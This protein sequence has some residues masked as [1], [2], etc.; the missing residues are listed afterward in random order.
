[1]LSRSHAHGRAW[2]FKGR[3]IAVILV[4]VLGANWG[5]QTWQRR[6]QALSEAERLVQSLTRVA[7]YQFAGSLRSVEALLDEAADRVDPIQWPQPELEAWFHARLAGYPELRAMQVIGLD[8]RRVGNVIVSDSEAAPHLAQG[9]PGGRDFFLQLQKDYAKQITAIGAPVPTGDGRFCIPV[10][11]AIIDRDGKFAGVVTAG[12][13]AGALREKL[14]SVAVEDDGGSGLFRRDALILARVPGHDQWLGK[15]V[16][17]SAVFKHYLSKSDTGIG[18]LIGVADGN[19][20]IIAYRSFANYPLV[21]V[22]GITI[23]SALAEWYQQVIKEGV[24]NI[25]V[26][27]ALLA[28]AT[29]Y[30]RRSAAN[31]QLL[32]E[33][34]ANRDDLER[35]VVERTAH[36][37]ATNAEL[38]QFT[39]IASHDLQEPLRS[40]SSFLQL[41]ERRYRGQLDAEA[42]EYIAF[43]VNGAKRMSALLNDVLA[44]SQ[45][46][47]VGLAPVCCD[48]ESL[49]REA[50]DSLAEQVKAVDPDIV[51]EPLPPVLAV[52]SQLLTLFQNLLGNALKYRALERRLRV[53]VSA[54]K[55]APG[56]VRISV[57]DNGIGI[58][59]QYHERIFKIFQRL[60]RRE[61]FEGTG[62][63]L[64]LC[65]KIVETVGG[66]LWVESTPGQ[67]SVFHFTLPLA[68]SEPN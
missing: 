67:G 59:P 7:E 19:D 14:E 50:L 16:P 68:E 43:A 23:H 30:D 27:V 6:A 52:P 10:A 65:E 2:S 21:V 24:A 58:D 40:V 32:H 9:A 18:Y 42:D 34:A 28:L 49:A 66:R 25:L 31:R 45:I 41:L 38:A 39:F 22:I 36:L 3:I 55:A 5:W 61:D 1:M 56:W 15:F 63:G 37:A 8:G 13:D 62:I 4:L 54:H 64:A 57:A 26:V 46:A 48:T 33:L 35:Q 12:I 17:E 53:I 20:K 60:N 11:R 29:L 47:R 44:Y 51:V